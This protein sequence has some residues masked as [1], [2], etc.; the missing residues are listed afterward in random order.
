MAE[1]VPHRCCPQGP[2]KTIAD[3]S[4]PRLT[5][6]RGASKG[7]RT[8]HFP[9]LLCTWSLQVEHTGC[10]LAAPSTP[11]RHGVQESRTPEGCA[12]LHHTQHRSSDGC[13]CCCCGCCCGSR[14]CTAAAPAPVPPSNI[15][16]ALTGG[17]GLSTP[18]LTA[19]LRTA[20]R[21]AA[22]NRCHARPMPRPCQ[23]RPAPA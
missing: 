7:C 12:A 16:P 8:P 20:N 5:H 1:H 22:M 3:S 4:Q 17:R 9:P 15:V 21:T 11:K 14:S 6:G 18:T 10:R 19:A 2:Q 13:C 23:R